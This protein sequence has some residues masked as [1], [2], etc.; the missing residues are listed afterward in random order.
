ML[1]VDAT[2]DP[3][4]AERYGVQRAPTTILADAQGHVIERLVGPENVRDRLRRLDEDA[5]TR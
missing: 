1:T 2:V 3:H 5:L 4:L